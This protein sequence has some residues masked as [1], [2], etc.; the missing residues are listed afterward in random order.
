MLF[1]S[2]FSFFSL[3]CAAASFSSFFAFAS[4]QAASLRLM[5]N[6][7]YSSATLEAKENSGEEDSTAKGYT[8]GALVGVGFLDGMPGFSLL[9][10][11]GLKI[12]GLKADEATS[13]AVITPLQATVE[14]G[15]EFS[16]I[17]LLRLQAL[18]GYDHLLSGKNVVKPKSAPSGWPSELEADLKKFNTLNLTGRALLTVAPFVSIGLE[19]TLLLSG[20]YATKAASVT[21]GN[22]KINFEESESKIKSGYSIKAVLA[23]TL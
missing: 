20:K 12:S 21:V 23:I 8:V 4:A 6:V 15:A 1:F 19:P 13:E 5:A 14:A 10:N 17:P 7:G 9:A 22:E 11:G 16:A 2:R 18:L 3:A